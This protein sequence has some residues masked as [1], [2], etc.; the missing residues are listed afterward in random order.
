MEHRFRRG[1]DVQK[2]VEAGIGGRGIGFDKIAV[3][4][5]HQIGQPV[6]VHVGKRGVGSGAQ[7]NHLVDEEAL[8]LQFKVRYHRRTYVPVEP[9]RALASLMVL[10]VGRSDHVLASA[11]VQIEIKGGGKNGNVDRHV[12]GGE[13]GVLFRHPGLVGAA[14]IMHHVQ[15]IEGD[16]AQH[17]FPVAV[18]IL[19][20]GHHGGAGVAFVAVVYGA[21]RETGRAA[22]GRTGRARCGIG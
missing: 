16:I 17:H 2:K 19:V 3:I 11:I 15:A 20:V 12:V 22:I 9:G 13:Q 5:H 1:P 4:A 21:G 6:R 10:S 18:A 7:V 8:G 14:A